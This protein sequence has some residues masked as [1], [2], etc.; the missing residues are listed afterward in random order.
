MTTTEQV[1]LIH[2][3]GGGAWEWRDWEPVLRQNALEPRSI[4]LMPTQ[5]GLAST[6]FEDYLTQVELWFDET[7]ADPLYPPAVI[8]ASLGGLLALKLAEVRPVSALVLVAPGPP[9][10]VTDWDYRRRDY[11]AVVSWA[12][13]LD[14]ADT[15]ASMPEADKATIAWA[16]GQWRDESGLV[17]QAICDG[18]EAQPPRCP[19][20]VLCGSEDAT[21]PPRVCLETAERLGTEH[22][23]YDRVSHLGALL[24]L[25]STILAQEAAGWLEAALRRSGVS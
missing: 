22:R 21:V 1:L 6:R 16:H 5:T 11:P 18:I 13:G 3:A 14:L 8:G 2:G 23:C 24:G 17:M 10:V 9:A 19:C 20:L 15:A 12:D 25:Y 7:Q 4:D